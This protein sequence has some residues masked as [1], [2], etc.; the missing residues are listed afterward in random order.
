MFLCAGSQFVV[1][2]RD[3]CFVR[4]DDVFA[5]AHGLQHERGSRLDAAEQFIVVDFHESIVICGNKK[6]VAFGCK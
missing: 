1:I 6:D 2:R 3:R 4:R 5:V